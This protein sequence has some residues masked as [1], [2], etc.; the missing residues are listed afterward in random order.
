MGQNII[1]DDQIAVSAFCV[2]VILNKESHCWDG[3]FYVAKVTK[4]CFILFVCSLEYIV[5]H[6]VVIY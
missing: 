5:A 2:S 3:H 6:L 4:Q 1:I